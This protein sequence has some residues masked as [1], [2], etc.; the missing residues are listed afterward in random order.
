MKEQ[1]GYH[2][3]IPI[4]F[5][6]QAFRL[7]LVESIFCQSGRDR[8]PGKWMMSLTSFLYSS[9]IFEE[10]ERIQLPNPAEAGYP[11]GDLFELL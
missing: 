2:L 3:Q 6:L 10:A 7:S 5:G 9:K 11:F 8:G 4:I 1:I